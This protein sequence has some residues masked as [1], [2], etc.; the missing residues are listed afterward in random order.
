MFG[1]KSNFFSSPESVLIK[2]RHAIK[3]LL[4][5]KEYA[6]EQINIYLKAYDFFCRNPFMYDGATIVKDLIDVPGIDLDALLHDYHYVVY[7]AGTHFYH[8]WRADWIL[9]KGGEK[10]GKGS[11]SSFSKFVGLTITGIF[12]TPYSYAKRGPILE[13]QKLAL[14]LDYKTLIK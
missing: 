3:N 11:Y 9:A 12:F 8:K 13:A 6:A 7:N 2:T 14:N 5:A 1:S 4:Y 10:K